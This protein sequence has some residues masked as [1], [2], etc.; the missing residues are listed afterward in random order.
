MGGTW[1]ASMVAALAASVG[2]PRWWVMALAAFLVRGGILVLL[3]PLVSLPSAPAV[4]TLLAPTVEAIAIGRQSFAAALI[5]A[6]LIA[7]LI[8]LDGE[9]N[10]LEGAQL[11]ALYL[12]LGIS[13]YF[14]G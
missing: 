5:G 1:A 13:F 2:R 8:S 14:S 10:W 12:M 11:L 6:A 4:A 7:V 3:L 9:S